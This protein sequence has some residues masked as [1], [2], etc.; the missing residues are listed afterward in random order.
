M[1]AKPDQ[2][3]SVEPSGEATVT[4]VSA[5]IAVLV[6]AGILLTGCSSDPDPVVSASA[7]AAPSASASAS[8]SAS[9]SAAPSPTSTLTAAEQEAFDE[10]TAAVMA[11]RQIG[12]DLYSGERTQINDL[13]D[14]T[15][16]T[17]RTQE[18]NGVAQALA[19]GYSSEPRGAQLELVGAEALKV[20]L[21][22]APPTV[23]VRACIDGTEVTIVDPE[24]ART[25]GVREVLDYT[26]IL[27]DWGWAVAEVAGERDPRDR[28]C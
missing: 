11:Y 13:D 9:P 14:F 6:V 15:T 5:R 16:G 18:V 2:Q 26:V 1:S 23:V 12:V 19:Q 20:R 4:G 17:L 22:K 21:Q 3:A 28:S 27:K 7:S 10:A 24:G 8:G 25:T